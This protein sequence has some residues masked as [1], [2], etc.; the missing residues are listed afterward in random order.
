M[1]VSLDGFVAGPNGEM[2]WIQFDDAMFAAVDKLHPEH[3]TALYGA[4]TFNMMETYWPTADE[5]PTAS[6][7]TKNHAHWYRQSLKLVVSNK[8]KAP[9]DKTKIISIDQIQH[10][11]Q[12]PGKNILMLGSPSI[13]H[14]INDLID[15]YWLYINPVILGTGIPMFK[16]VTQKINLKLVEAI[17][18]KAGVVALHYKKG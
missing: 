11:K 5:K 17:P 4:N 6:S 10:E 1:H 2:D 15:E 18:Y 13:A 14:Q 8:L 16:D 9:N 3:D 7:H 12:Q